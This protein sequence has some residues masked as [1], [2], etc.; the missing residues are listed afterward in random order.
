MKRYI[1]SLK[2]IKYVENEPM[3]FGEDYIP[4]NKVEEMLSD[5]DSELSDVE[6]MLMNQE[7]GKCLQK[8]EEIR[9]RL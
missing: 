8:L 3:S 6:N 9:E 2:P 5:I 4:L 1:H 7:I